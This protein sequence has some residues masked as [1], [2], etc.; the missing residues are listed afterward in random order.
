MSRVQWRI[1]H[2][3]EAVKDSRQC[4][5]DLG[6][7]GE[8]WYTVWSHPNQYGSYPRDAVRWAGGGEAA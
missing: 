6:H 5:R 2:Q 4:E 3:C 8:H 1:F 7:D